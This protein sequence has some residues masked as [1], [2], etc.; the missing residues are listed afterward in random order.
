MSVIAGAGSAPSP[1]PKSRRRLRRLL[2]GFLAVV[3]VAAGIAAVHW[4]THP[5]TF[6]DLGDSYG[7]QP[8][9]VADA[10]LSTTVI[11]PQTSGSPEVVEIEGLDATFSTNTA[12]AGVTFSICHMAADEDPIGAVFEPQSTCG[13]IEPFEAP[14]RF[15]HGVDPNSD[16]LFVTITPTRAGVA[17]LS[18]ID[19]DYRRPEHFHQR[20][21]QTIQVGAEVNAR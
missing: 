7:T 19:V 11:Y 5:T 14:A 6:R 15:N 17:R 13:D 4:W 9:P 2:A 8:L 1:R 16:Y 10:A 3:V 21:T 12:K 18:S 20:G